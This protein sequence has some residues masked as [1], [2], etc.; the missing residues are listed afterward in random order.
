MEVVTRNPLFVYKLSERIKQI[1]F[2]L[3]GFRFLISVSDES[4]EG[5]SQT[6]S[7]LSLTLLAA[8]DL[9]LGR[10]PDA[11]K[12]WASFISPPRFLGSRTF[13]LW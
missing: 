10:L 6:S 4:G 5:V 8:D 7:V 2:D 3:G 13:R 11:E 1:T 12:A 9:L